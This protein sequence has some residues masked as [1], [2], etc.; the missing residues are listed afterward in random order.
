MTALI[1]KTDPRWFAQT[2]NKPYDRHI[3]KVVFKN[4]VYKF[5]SWDAAMGCWFEKKAL[6]QFKT[7]EVLDRKKKR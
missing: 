6:G 4:K 7:I 1:E 3:Y 2:C 5:D